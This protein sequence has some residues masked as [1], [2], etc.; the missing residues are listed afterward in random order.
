MG[1]KNEAVKK[2][3]DM[4]YQ[5]PLVIDLTAPL[6]E[7]VMLSLLTH[8]NGMREVERD[9]RELGVVPAPNEKMNGGFS[10]S[11][12]DPY[13][14]VL[15]GQIELSDDTY[16]KDREDTYAPSDEQSIGA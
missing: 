4:F 7:N 11:S 3:S 16:F 8:I 9:Y 15:T 13:F 12:I 5:H 6:H 10:G 1:K 2:Y 14:R